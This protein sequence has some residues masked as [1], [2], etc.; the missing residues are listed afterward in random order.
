VASVTMLVGISKRAAAPVP[1]AEPKWPADP[2]S[3]VTTA[4]GVILRIAAFAPRLRH[5]MPQSRVIY[6]LLLLRVEDFW[7]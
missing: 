6:R 3:V 1:S 4:A 2:A 5:R 7:N